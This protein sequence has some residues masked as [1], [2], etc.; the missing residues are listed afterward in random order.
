MCLYIF[1]KI[2]VLY[3]RKNIFLSLGNNIYGDEI[4]TMLESI[5]ATNKRDAYILMERINPPYI[6]NCIVVR[7][8][9][10]VMQTVICELGIFGVVLG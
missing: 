2:I 7:D 10:P 9:P 4:K 1:S 5:K 8:K 6:P 3:I